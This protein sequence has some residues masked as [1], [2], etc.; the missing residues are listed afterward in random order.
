MG[1]KDH[2]LD[3]NG[4]HKMP[5][6]LGIFFHNNSY[7]FILSLHKIHHYL[8]GTLSEELLLSNQVSC[9]ICNCNL[10]LFHKIHHSINNQFQAPLHSNT[11]QLL[12]I[13]LFVLSRLLYQQP[14]QINYQHQH[15]FQVPLWNLQIYLSISIHAIQLHAS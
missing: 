6:Q 12:L 10:L 1:M 5:L 2:L 11:F 14:Y 4:H 9:M 7:Q 13:E 8:R 3:R 15:H